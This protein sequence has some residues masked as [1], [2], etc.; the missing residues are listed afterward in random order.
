MVMGDEGDSELQ[1]FLAVNV[2]NSI[3][4]VQKNSS[5]FENQRFDTNGFADLS[6]FPRDAI[7][8]CQPLFPLLV[9]DRWFRR[10]G[11]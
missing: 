2:L 10:Q 4:P 1:R 9:E 6:C 8:I 11:C 3:C 5:I 7:D